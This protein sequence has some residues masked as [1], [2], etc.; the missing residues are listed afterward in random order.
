MFNIKKLYLNIYLL[1]II[2]N[3]YTLFG[4]EPSLYFD[5]LNIENI[6]LDLETITIKNENKIDSPSNSYYASY[7]LTPISRLRR[8]I[9]WKLIEKD[10]GKYDSY[11]QFKQFWNPSF[12][13]R[14]LLKK[15]FHDFK[16]NPIEFIKK[17]IAFNN[18]KSKNRMERINNSHK[19]TRYIEGYG[20]IS[21]SK[22]NKYN[23]SG[24][25]IENSK[26]LRKN[27]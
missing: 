23:R 8:K 16:E 1:Y 26:L 21:R 2:L 20:W 7:P 24:F 18:L 14:G 5:S 4:I 10:S 13:F 12:K 27:I 15:E 17:E 9:Y 11:D 6:N 25:T 19:G 22:L 3:I